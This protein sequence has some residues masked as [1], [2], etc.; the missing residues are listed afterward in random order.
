[1]AGI[2]TG[3]DPVELS[4][5]LENLLRIGTIH[6]VDHA[7]AR[8]R[9]QTGALTSQWLPWFAPR[10]GETTVWS[11]PTV[12]E[13]A[14]ILS[15]SG[16][17]AGGVVLVGIFSDA[18]PAPSDSADEH[19]IVFPDGA[20]I[21]YDHASSHLSVSGIQTATVQAATH[22]TV[23][24]PETETTGNLTVGGNIIVAGDATVNGSTMLEGEA[25]VAGLLSY[26]SGLA[27][28]GGA[29]GGSTMIAG[30]ISHASGNLSSNGITLHTHTHGGVQGGSGSTGAPQ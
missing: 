5:R 21:S 3:M 24:C 16:E 14:M 13:Q 17:A 9:V 15:P 30:D 18:K 23:D 6:S 19:L 8:C 27:G 11:P 25:I 10:A 4:R 26:M 22:C 2:L 1:V 28:T 29:G 7:E 12:G 20:R